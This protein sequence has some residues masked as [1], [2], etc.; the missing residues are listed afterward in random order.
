MLATL[1]LRGR[2]LGG[3]VAK[4]LPRPVIAGEE[5]RRVVA[6]IIGDV[7]AHGDRVLTELTARFDGVTLE[8]IEVP[9]EA[10]D[11][12]VESLEPELRAAMEAA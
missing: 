4:L 1:D 10:L 6:D 9:T 12:A 3:D 11:A 5:P 7:R 8:A 2:D